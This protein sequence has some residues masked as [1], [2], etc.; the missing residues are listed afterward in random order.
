MPIRDCH[1]ASRTSPLLTPT[2]WLQ[3]AV[4]ASFPYR[5]YLI[6]KESYSK[7]LIFCIAMMSTTLNM[8]LWFYY[9]ANIHFLQEKC[10]YFSKIPFIFHNSMLI[11]QSPHTKCT[12][13]LLPTDSL[14][15]QAPQNRL[16]SISP[17]PHSLN[18]NV[19]KAPDSKPTGIKR[20]KEPHPKQPS[21]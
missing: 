1:T 11:L 5:F 20:K 7:Q 6:N 16:Q 13:P 3:T 4:P 18:S 12:N 19:C 2:T 15:R 9:N 17:M 10:I 14:F 21:F 8:T